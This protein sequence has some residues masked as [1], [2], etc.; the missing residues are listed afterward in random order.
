MTAKTCFRFASTLVLAFTLALW[1]APVRA[2]DPPAGDECKEL[3]QDKS[4]SGWIGLAECY[5]KAGNVD[6]AVEAARQARSAASIPE[7][8]VDASQTLACALLDQPDAQAKTEAADLFK[9][10]MASSGG[11][12]ARAGYYLTLRELHR[13]G[14][15]AEFL[16]SLKPGAAQGGGE[17]PPCRT[18]NPR[19]TQTWNEF[20]DVLDLEAPLRV[21]GAVTR[22]ELIR[23][24][25]PVITDEARKHPGFSGAVILEAIID[26]QGRIQNPRVLKG[27]PYGLNENAIE[28]LKQWRFKP[29]TLEGKPVKV[30]YVLTVTFTVT[31]DR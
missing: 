18:L 26:R 27:Q 1:G 7:E 9:E 8:R 23:M 28:S 4:V 25:K 14:E 10:N 2:Q 30:Y 17:G 6:K 16:R 19:L 31:N 20:A 13:D 3:S 21:G 24:A 15:A 12:R 5:Q 22:P 11:N 29:A